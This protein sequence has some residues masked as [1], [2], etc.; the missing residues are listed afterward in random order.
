MRTEHDAVELERELLWIEFLV[1]VPFADGDARRLRELVDPV[2]LRAHESIARGTGPVI[3]LATHA[4]E[5]AAA[6]PLAPLHPVVE[7]GAQA[8]FA[9]RGAECGHH[10]FVHELARGFFDDRDLERFLRTEVSEQAA[11]REARL[12]RETTDREPRN[13]DDRGELE[14]LRQNRLPR[15]FALAHD[16]KNRTVVLFVNA[17]AG[18]VRTAQR[19]PRDYQRFEISGNGLSFVEWGVAAALLPLRAAVL[20][21]GGACGRIEFDH[22]PL[23]STVD[24][25]IVPEG[26][27]PCDVSKDFDAPVLID[28]LSDPA[29]SDGTLR[30]LPDELSG[31]YWSGVANG[32]NGAQEIYF[33]SRPTWSAPFTSVRVTGVN[34]A[35]DELDPALTSD[36]T[37]LVF[38]RSGPGDDLYFAPRQTPDTFGA[39]TAIAS[40]NTTSGEAQ[41]FIPIGTDDV[42]FQSRRTGNGDLYLSRRTGTTFTAPTLIS[43]VSTAAEEGDP[44]VTPDGLAIYF[45]SNRT[46]PLG[47][48][49]IYVATRASATGTFGAATLVPNL[50]SATDDGP[51]WISADGCRLYMSSDRAGTN[52]I[53]VA[54]RPL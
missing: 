19:I 4:D 26:P 34:S 32:P 37:L 49:N 5:E 42:Y 46:A 31:Y 9:A 50:N 17:P 7:Q 48:F 38:R 33:A 16:D 28:E 10:D 22:Q 27:P 3:E 52:D 14:C 8:R 45:R 13:A 2:L 6:G 44:V 41:V 12:F 35:T 47:G 36:G 24:A 18:T 1:E 30:L 23:P 20:L 40:L 11:L 54:T 25:A 29:V 43:D 51:S 15:L 39:P 21:V 53:Y